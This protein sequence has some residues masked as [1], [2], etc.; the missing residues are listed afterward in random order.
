VSVSGRLGQGFERFRREI[1]KRVR[2]LALFKLAIAA[3]CAAAT[4]HD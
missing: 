3:S 1:A 2:D 4:S